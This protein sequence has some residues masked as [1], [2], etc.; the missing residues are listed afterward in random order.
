MF[1]QTGV[2]RTFVCFEIP[3]YV[4]D[5]LATIQERLRKSDVEV[6]WV[7]VGNIHLTVEFLGGVSLDRMESVNQGIGRAAEK[8]QPIR[9][10]LAKLGCFP[11]LEHPRVI[12][13]GPRQVPDALAI[14]CH[15]VKKELTA[16]GFS[17]QSRPFS[18]HF[19]LG[20]VRSMQKIDTLARAIKRE[21]LE[22]VSFRLT[23][24]T[25]MAS[26]QNS[27][28]IWYTPISR[29]TLGCPPLNRNSLQSIFG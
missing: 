29:S 16:A 5:H 12:W 18:P 7:K 14:F 27:V 25:V 17:I 15:R 19:T 20:R 26:Q 6:S 24:V 4:G 28:G 3:T 11:N 1:T 22:P 21:N 8:G 9:L 23:K 13:V 2:L 10:E